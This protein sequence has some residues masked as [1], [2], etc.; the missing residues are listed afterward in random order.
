MLPAP[1][2]PVDLEAKRDRRELVVRPAPPAVPVR[3]VQEDP[4]EPLE[5]RDLMVLMVPL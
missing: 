3:L 2:D 5:I 4:Q 1:P